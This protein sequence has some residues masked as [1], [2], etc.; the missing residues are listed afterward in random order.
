MLDDQNPA[1]IIEVEVTD[2]KIDAPQ[3]SQKPKRP[4][5]EY[6]RQ[7]RFW[8]FMTN[9]FTR[10]GPA[11]FLIGGMAGLAFSILT[12][13]TNYEGFNFVCMIIGWSLCGAGLLA[14]LFSLFARFMLRH[15][16]A[17]DPNFSGE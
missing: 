2:E 17:L 1:D 3:T 6:S 9:M 11:L 4:I 13:Q 16:M 12:S 8:S 15:Y 5:H 14:T 7:I 10:Y